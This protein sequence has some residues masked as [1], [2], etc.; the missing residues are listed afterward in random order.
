MMRVETVGEKNPARLQQLIKLCNEQ[1]N[2]QPTQQH[3]RAST[4]S[5]PAAIS[6]AVIDDV[7]SKSTLRNT[8]IDKASVGC[9]ESIAADDTGSMLSLDMLRLQSATPDLAQ[10][11]TLPL[12]LQS[13][14]S[15][16][17]TLSISN[18]CAARDQRTEEN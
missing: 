13:A 2:K 3:N 16:T 6:S 8:T 7:S 18:G 1:A 17:N 12:P 15:Q 10:P 9:A 14:P 5:I 11:H 4:S